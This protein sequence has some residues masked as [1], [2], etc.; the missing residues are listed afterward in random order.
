MWFINESELTWVLDT[1]DLLCALIDK[2]HK[3]YYVNIDIS[4]LPCVS[5][6]TLICLVYANVVVLGQLI[7]ATEC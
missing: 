6:K 2:I 7:S 4:K 5:C 3:I 1:S